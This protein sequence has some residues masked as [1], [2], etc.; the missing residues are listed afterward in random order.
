M[1]A[2]I[3]LGQRPRGLEG[4]QD[5]RSGVEEERRVAGFD[6]IARVVSAE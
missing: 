5:A 3:S 2:S 1:I 4:D 6:Q